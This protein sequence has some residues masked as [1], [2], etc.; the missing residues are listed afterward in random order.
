MV[1]TNSQD[2]S[3]KDQV[4]SLILLINPEIVV[5]ARMARG[6]TCPLLKPGLL[7]LRTDQVICLVHFTI[8]IVMLSSSRIIELNM[9]KL[10]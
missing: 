10:L 5:K 4:A 6:R 3:S 7:A 8:V 1:P 9:R 2:C